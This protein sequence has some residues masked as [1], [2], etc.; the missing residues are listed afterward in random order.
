MLSKSS[1]ILG[2]FGFTVFALPDC[3]SSRR[4][5]I[6]THRKGLK[7]YSTINCYNEENKLGREGE[8]GSRAPYITKSQSGDSFEPNPRTA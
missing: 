4:T 1:D 7:V 3:D 2:V 5:G 8:E 6:S